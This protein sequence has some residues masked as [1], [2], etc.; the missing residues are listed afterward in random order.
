MKDFSTLVSKILQIYPDEKLDLRFKNPFEL[1][2]AAILAAQSKDEVV[3]SCT[4]NLFKKFDSPEKFSKLN[5]EDLKPYIS[6]INFWYKKAKTIIDASNYI[7]KNYGGKVPDS[8]EELIKIKGVG[9]KTANMILGAAFGKPAVITD[10]H[11]QR[12]SKRLGIVPQDA[13]PSEI[14]E[15]IKKIVPEENL[16]KF[17]LALMRHGKKVC[18]AKK[19]NCIVC[20]IKNYCEFFRS[21]YK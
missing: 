1:L 7:Q 8:Y 6:K 17:S 15:T 12:V 9:S 2:V 4:E 5:P 14:E 20:D 13:E 11:V 3:N 19:P 21:Q 18:Q 16:T 10:T